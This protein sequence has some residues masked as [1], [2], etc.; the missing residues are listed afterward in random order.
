MKK[1]IILLIL[2]PFSI[3]MV[4][5]NYYLLYG[6][7][8]T[9]NGKYLEVIILGDRGAVAGVTNLKGSQE[10]A[11]EA[12]LRIIELSQY[13]DVLKLRYNSSTSD[14]NGVVFVNP[15]WCTYTFK[16]DFSSVIVDPHR[17]T[18][19][20]ELKLCEYYPLQVGNASVNANTIPFNQSVINNTHSN[21]QYNST[22][23]PTRQFKCAYCNGTGRIER[24]DN[25]PASFGQ[26]KANIAVR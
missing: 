2:L 23:Q 5:Q 18:N 19:R 26:S 22:A 13:T 9:D 1:V 11:N 7:D 21:K 25:A 24:N 14:A 10:K 3:V 20:H 12:A 8:Q 4:A 15:T 16:P 17:Y 6:P